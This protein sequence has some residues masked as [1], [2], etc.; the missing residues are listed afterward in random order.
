[1]TALQPAP[2]VGWIDV[3]ARSTDWSVA[4]DLGCTF[5][6]TKA[7]SNPSIPK[8]KKAVASQNDWQRLFVFSVAHLFSKPTE[9]LE[10][11]TGGGELGGGL[12]SDALNGTDTDDDDQGQHDR[13]FDCRWAVFGNQEILDAA[14]QMCHLRF[15]YFYCDVTTLHDNDE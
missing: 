10:C 2:C 1:M 6:E 3:D 15:S 11:C 14:H 5:A 13:I 12:R 4:C 7:P 9:L 8:T